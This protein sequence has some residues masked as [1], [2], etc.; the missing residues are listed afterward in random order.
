M[1]AER[2]RI[3]AQLSEILVPFESEPSF[4]PT[5]MFPAD[6]YKD[7]TRYIQE[8]LRETQFEDADHAISDPNEF[9]IRI[10]YKAKRSHGKGYR[11]F[12]NTIVVL[13]LRRYIYEHAAH[14]PS[15][16]VLDTP[17]L[18]L[19]HQKSGSD[20]VT[21]RDKNGRP[22]T[23]LLRNLYDHMVDTGEYGQLII[24]NNTDSTP[25]THF[26]GENTTELVFGEH[27]EADR[28]GL[29]I[30]MREA[31]GSEYAPLEGQLS[32]FDE[33]DNDEL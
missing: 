4:D 11:A 31:H 17:T 6:F 19:E 10:R 12:F 13:A 22:R 15:V 33:F 29:L 26:E 2:D 7:M 14:K 3:Q 28:P 9:D 23:G 21:S 20:L 8:I 5:A 27:E 25:T 1:E 32:F 24:L 30:D 16:I 18:G